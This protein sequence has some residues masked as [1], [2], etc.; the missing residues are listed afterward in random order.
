M[1]ISILVYMGC[2]CIPVEAADVISYVMTAAPAEIFHYRF[3]AS[4]MGFR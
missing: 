2:V 1:V 4:A 3:L